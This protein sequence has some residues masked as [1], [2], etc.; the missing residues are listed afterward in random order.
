MK[1]PKEY[2]EILGKSH[3]PFV[4][5]DVK[6]TESHHTP[7]SAYDLSQSFDFTEALAF[8]AKDE[9]FATQAELAENTTDQSFCTK[10]YFEKLGYSPAQKLDQVLEAYK[11]LPSEFKNWAKEKSLGPKDFKPFLKDYTP[12][13][14]NLFTHIGYLKASKNSG[15]QIIEY[16][17]DLLAVQK[18][19]I[20]DCLNFKN[21]DRLLKFLKK[22]RFKKSLEKDERLKSQISKLHIAENTKLDLKREGDARKILLEIKTQSLDELEKSLTKCLSKLSEISKSLGGE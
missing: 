9:N 13:L 21:P 7:M 20:E 17:L 4:W 16:G 11:A 14:K 2:Y 8:M 6:L 5:K 19:S 1:P 3:C 10:L 22:L 18:V 15:L 12:D